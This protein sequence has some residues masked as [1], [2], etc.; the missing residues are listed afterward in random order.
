MDARDFYNKNKHVSWTI[1]EIPLHLS[2]DYEIAKWILNESSIGWIELDIKFDTHEW[3]KESQAAKFVNHRGNNHP[4][5]NSACI[6]GIDVDKTGSWTN[7]GY[8][9]EKNVPYRWTSL[10]EHTP[11]IKK[12]W[13]E[14][15][16]EKYRRIRFMELEPG[17]WISPHSDAPGKLPGEDSIDIL[18]FGVPINLAIVHPADCHMTLDGYGCIPWEEGKAFMINIRNY[19]SVINFSMVSRIHLIAHGMPGNRKKDFVELIVRSYRKQ[20]E[21]RN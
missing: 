1:P 4:G 2:N 7:Y 10:S 8:T 14:F 12:F 13:E 16:Y 3:K 21:K 6:H 18:E 17:G 15:P 5:W 9:D 11:T 20:Y 19:H